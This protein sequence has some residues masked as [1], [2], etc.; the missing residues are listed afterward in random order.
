MSAKRVLPGKETAAIVTLMVAFLGV[1]A[2]VVPL[3]IGFPH[4]S[5]VAVTNLTRKR[6]LSLIIVGFH[7]SLEIVTPAEE[8][9][10][11]LDLTLKVGLLACCQSPRCSARPV[12]SCLLLL[13]LLMLLLLRRSLF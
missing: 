11:A 8:L 4:E 13:M 2:L 6:V 7:V 9:S 5:L 10:A 3:K 1:H 12:L